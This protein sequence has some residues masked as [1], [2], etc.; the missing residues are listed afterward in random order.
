MLFGLRKGACP[1]TSDAD[2]FLNRK[3]RSTNQRSARVQPREILFVREGSYFMSIESNVLLSS[4]PIHK[5]HALFAKCFGDCNVTPDA[6][7]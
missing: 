6:I 3:T 1:A 5:P 7:S 2:P 4:D